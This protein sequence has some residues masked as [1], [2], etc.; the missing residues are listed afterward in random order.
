MG[1]NSNKIEIIYVESMHDSLRYVIT[2]CLN[3]QEYKLEPKNTGKEP[4]NMQE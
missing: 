1:K 3:M 2:S 4:K